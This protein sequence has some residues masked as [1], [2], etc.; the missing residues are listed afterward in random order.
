MWCLPR[1]RAAA[2]T[3]VPAAVLNIAAKTAAAI[4]LIVIITVDTHPT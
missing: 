4:L 1:S 2:L 3:C